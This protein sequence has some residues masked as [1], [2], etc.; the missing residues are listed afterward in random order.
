MVKLFKSKKVE[1]K[2]E[3]KEENKIEKVEKT[4]EKKLSG[5]AWIAQK[6][7]DLMR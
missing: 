5:S 4:E 2:V 7:N 1:K 6:L 3:N